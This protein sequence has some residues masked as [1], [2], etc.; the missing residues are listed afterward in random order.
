MSPRATDTTAAAGVGAV[1]S[2]V[3]RMD[4]KK[5]TVT[6]ETSSAQNTVSHVDTDPDYFDDPSLL[7]QIRTNTL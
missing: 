2:T 5:T 6:L 4:S 7:Q 3:V 1:Y